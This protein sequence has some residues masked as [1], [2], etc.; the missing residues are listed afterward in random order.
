MAARQALP[1]PGPATPR[2][3]PL[4]DVAWSLTPAAIMGLAFVILTRF[5]RHTPLTPRELSLDRSLTARTPA[6][7]VDLSHAVDVQHWAFVVLGLAV[8]LVLARRYRQAL[9]LILAEVLA[10]GLNAA[11]KIAVDR[12][13]PDQGAV[14]TGSVFDQFDVLLFPSGHVVRTSVTLGLFVLFLAWP[15][16]RARVPAAIGAL[17]AMALIGVTQVAVGGHL[18]LD[19]LGGYLLAGVIVNVIYV[20]DRQFVRKRSPRLKVARPHAARLARRIDPRTALYA[21][22]VAAAASVVVDH[23]SHPRVLLSRL[24]DWID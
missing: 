21:V 14:S 15:Y 19:A 12:Q 7:F 8:V 3:S 22:G 23:L 2:Q 1:D 13:F 16:P 5:V 17:G 24:H 9:L 10:E 11:I 20:L 4:A 6:N 18:P